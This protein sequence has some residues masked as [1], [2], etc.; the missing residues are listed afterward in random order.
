M[1]N[2]INRLM[3]LFI[4]VVCLP[5]TTLAETGGKVVA[6]VDGVKLTEA[7]LN[8]EIG[9]IMP[10]NQAFHGKLSEEKMNKVRS[11]AM[12]NLVGS[13][14]KAQDASHKG[15]KIPA[16]VVTEE[17]N[18]M[19]N[20]FK[21][22]EGFVSAY[23]SSGFTEKSLSRMVERRL[24][25]DKI[26][27]AEIDG[28]VTI[29][30]EKVKR[31]YTDNVSR[32]SKPE[33]FRASQILV[34]VDPSSTSEQ[35]LVL[36][37]KADRLLKRINNGEKFEELAINESDDLSKINGGDLGYFHSGQAV[38]EFEDALMKMKVGEVSN[39]VETLYG[40]HI[41]RLTDRRPPRQVPFDEI[42]DKINNDL[43]A[44]EKKQLMEEWMNGLY[45]K[46]K[47]TYPGEK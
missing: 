41:I 20:K 25:A 3:I 18:K 11:E 26:Q 45:K 47:I 24:L 31:Y 32:Y 43:V 23:T 40:Y 6:V 10:M 16:L 22:K 7:E 8:Q 19:S 39:V 38:Q 27:L 9:I 44:S 12:K 17:M 2:S 36:R 4:L 29:T 28:K 15:I 34:K 37:S 5:M 13:E 14:L 35:R 1:F 33:E 30:P 21:S 46:A 42:Q